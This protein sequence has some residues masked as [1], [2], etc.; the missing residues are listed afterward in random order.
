[1]KSAFAIV[2]A[3]AISVVS[4]PANAQGGLV[5]GKPAYGGPGCPAGT[6][7]ASLGSDGKSLSLRFTRYQVA[8]DGR[9]GRSFD[10]KSC[11]LAIPVH[12]PAGRSVS[13]LSMAFSGYNQLPSSGK[14]ELRFESFFAGGQ[15]PVFARSF[16]GPLQ[17]GFAVKQSVPVSSVIW[18]GCGADVI[19]RTN[20]SLIVHTAPNQKAAAAIGSQQVRTAV[21]YTLQSRAC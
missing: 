20:S 11:N 18:S 10:R 9:T 6:A 1:M 13:I 12:V 8:A 7:S 15:G 21:V 17:A 4:L 2:I 19:L 16:S 5:L 3:L 14:S